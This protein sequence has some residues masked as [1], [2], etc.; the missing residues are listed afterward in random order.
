LRQ[1][2]WL[3]EIAAQRISET[4]DVGQ[5]MRRGDQFGVMASYARR[6]KIKAGKE[7]WVHRV[8]V[9][10]ARALLWREYLLVMRTARGL[11]VAMSFMPVTFA[12]MLVILGRTGS[13]KAPVGPLMMLA[14]AGSVVMTVMSM[15][16]YGYLETLRKVDLLKPLP[17]SASTHVLYEVICK[18]V[19]AIALP[20]FVGAATIPFILREWQWIVAALIVMPG[21]AV[22]LA[23][24]MFDLAVL[25]PDIDDASQRAFRG[26]MQMLGFVLFAAPP[27]GTFLGVY[28]FTRSAVLAAIPAAVFGFAIGAGAAVLGGSLYAGHNPAE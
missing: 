23:A 14:L 28:L 21:L 27:V 26:L 9:Q 8:R 2:P 20:T 25:F 22:L 4:G 1:S 24:I 19:V 11:L 15:A 16:Q 13:G 7:S 17:F 3:Y 12:V 6:G 5:Q 10:G 18:A